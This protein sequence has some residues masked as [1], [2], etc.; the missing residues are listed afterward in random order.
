MMQMVDKMLLDFKDGDTLN[1]TDVWYLFNFHLH[2]YL[3][4]KSALE[5]STE[6]D[7]L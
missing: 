5:C 6:F 4:L 7:S 3:K 2:E 1:R